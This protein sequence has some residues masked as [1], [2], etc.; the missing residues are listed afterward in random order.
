MPRS[1]AVLLDSLAKTEYNIFFNKNQTDMNL[2]QIKLYNQKQQRLYAAKTN[3]L[4]DIQ[5]IGKNAETIAIPEKKVFEKIHDGVWLKKDVIRFS[6][7]NF[8]NVYDLSWDRKNVSLEPVIHSEK[9]PYYMLDYMEENPSMIAIMNGS[10]FFLVDFPER[11]PKDYPFHFCVRNGKVIGLLSSDEAIIYIK[12][13]ELFAKDAKAVGELTIGEK[14]LKWVGFWHTDE[15]NDPKTAVL[16]NSGSLKLI[17]EFDPKTGVRVGRIDPR[18]IRT[19]TDPKMVDLIINKIDGRM[20]VSHINKG[21]GTHY[22]EGLFILQIREKYNTFNMGDA[23]TPLTLDGLNLE[24]ITSGITIN[25]SVTDPYFYTT[26]RINSR[27]ARSVIAQDKSGNTHFVVF[28]GCKYVPKFKGV[29]ANDVKDYFSQDKYN[30]AYFL[31]GG[32]SSRIIVRKNKGREFFGS[33]FAFKKITNEIFLWDSK[34]HRK[35]ASS[36]ALRIRRN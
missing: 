3:F 34:R 36:I 4:V 22:F 35:L 18:Y 19:K 15:K 13:G 16:Y 30:W 28:D 2:K 29:S 32:S 10:F 8:T 17:K 21:G 1:E 5:N 11:E 14:H 27:D 12:E 23:V 6:D 26:D 9:K 25:K 20:V 24:D 33:E 7:G 31:D